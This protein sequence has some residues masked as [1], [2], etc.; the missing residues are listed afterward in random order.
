MYVIYAAKE[1]QLPPSNLYI[2]C[3][4]EYAHIHMHT[5]TSRTSTTV[6]TPSFVRVAFR[7]ATVLNRN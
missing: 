4:K 6:T 5:Y 1:V 2:T 3:S 7:A